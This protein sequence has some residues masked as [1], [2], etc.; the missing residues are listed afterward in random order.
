MNAKNIFR[1]MVEINFVLLLLAGFFRFLNG[2]S[3]ILKKNPV[4]ICVFHA[5]TYVENM[6]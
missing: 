3:S 5:R 6:Q 2:K 1:K 4:N